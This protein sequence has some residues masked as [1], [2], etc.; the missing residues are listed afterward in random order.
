MLRRSR[1]ATPAVAVL[2]CATLLAG[3]FGGG[4]ENA[5]APGAQ[6]LVPVTGIRPGQL[7]DSFSDARSGGRT[8]EAIDIPAPKGTPVLAAASGTI[9]RMSQSTLGGTTLYERDADGRTVYYYAH[10][11]GYA[12]GAKVGREVKRGEVIAYVGDTGNAGPGNY[13]LHFGVTIVTDRK[14]V[15]GGVAVNPYPL[16]RGRS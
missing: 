14:R 12:P 3:C 5:P 16:L 1:S 11:S 7:H 15:S 2:A 6:L 8:H 10:L 4:P 13:H 9:A